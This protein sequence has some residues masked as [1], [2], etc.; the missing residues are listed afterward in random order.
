MDSQPV[1]PPDPSRGDRR[2]GRAGVVR[3][4]LPVDDVG[5]VA[6]RASWRHHLRRDIHQPLAAP[7]PLL[8]SPA[9]G[10][11]SLLH[12]VRPPRCWQLV[13][14]SPPALSRR[15]GPVG[16]SSGSDLNPADRS[17]LDLRERVGEVGQELLLAGDDAVELKDAGFQLGV[18]H[19]LH[20]GL[21]ARQQQQRTL[22]HHIGHQ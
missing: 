15:H 21:R 22:Q 20:E 4:G 10:V 11:R 12:R 17:R 2:G 1:V 16:C 6:S 8:S 13:W 18:I 5:D 9:L 3:S 19:L 7:A 14:V